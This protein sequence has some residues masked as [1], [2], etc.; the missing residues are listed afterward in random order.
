MTG[1]LVPYGGLSEIEVKPGDTVIVAPSTG[2][3]GGGAATMALAMGATVVACGRNEKT[4]NHMKETFEKLHPGRLRTVILT[5]DVEVDTKAII[6]A[7]GN[8]GKG[9]DAYIDFSPGVAAKDGTPNYIESA[10]AALRPRGRAAFMGG[11]FGKVEIPYF[12][13]VLKSLRIQG[14]FMYE[15]EMVV[16]V[17]LVSYHP[18]LDGEIDLMEGWMRREMLTVG[19]RIGY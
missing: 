19:N 15:R 11:I 10:L 7:S 9:A 12:P 3:F 14:R 2:R 4:L 1:F 18:R 6:A 8:K 13:I 5:G 17:C 16:Q